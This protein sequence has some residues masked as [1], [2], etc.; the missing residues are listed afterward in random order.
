M[1]Y[2]RV[3]VSAAVELMTPEAL[4]ELLRV[5]RQNNAR[6]GITGML[7]YHGGTF[8]QAFEGEKEAVERLYTRIAA[9]ARHRGIIPLF[10]GT[11]AERQFGEWTMGFPSYAA[12]LAAEPAFRNLWEREVPLDLTEASAGHARQLLLSFRDQMRR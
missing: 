7:F 11:I 10:Q 4:A 2:Q 1:L 8:M 6:D 5:S 3:Y 12:V 9:D